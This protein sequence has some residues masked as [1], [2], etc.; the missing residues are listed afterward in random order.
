MSEVKIFVCLVPR[1]QP[2]YESIKSLHKA[3]TTAI[4]SGIAFALCD[5]SGGVPGWRNA[6]VLIPLFLD[7][8]N[9][10]HMF[11]AADDLLYPSDIFGQLIGRH[12]P[13]VS[14]IYRK[15]DGD[16]YTACLA[17][18]EEDQSLY[19]K[20]FEER[21]CYPA[22]YAAGHTMLIERRVI[23]KMISDY[24]ELHFDNPN[25]GRVEYGLFLPMIEDRIGHN[26]DTAFCRRAKKSGFDSFNDYN[27]Q[28][29][30]YCGG[31]LGFS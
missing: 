20:H 17:N 5:I 22:P 6:S 16:I 10:T 8:K 25:T 11:L 21:G 23:E 15:R 24:P 9:A 2:Y 18:F 29:L 30:H 14:G 27:C 1:E 31:F 12:K 4:A 19:A 13:I 28:C 26:D 3:L 7:D